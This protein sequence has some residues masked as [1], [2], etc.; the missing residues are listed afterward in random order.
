MKINNTINR[1]HKIDDI[2][3]D[4]AKKQLENDI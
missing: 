4:R 1:W 3:C 2:C